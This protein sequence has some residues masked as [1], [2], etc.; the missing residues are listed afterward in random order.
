MIKEFHRT[1]P[2]GHR[3]REPPNGRHPLGELVG[4]RD[5]R[6]QTDQLHLGWEVDD[7]LFPYGPPISVLEEVHLIEDHEGEIIEGF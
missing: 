3:A 4:I 2:L 6:R 7:D 5:G 1:S